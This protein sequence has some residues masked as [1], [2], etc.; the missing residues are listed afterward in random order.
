MHKDTI[1]FWTELLNHARLV[2]RR[3][4]VADVTEIEQWIDELEASVRAHI[5]DEL[6]AVRARIKEKRRVAVGPQPSRVRQDC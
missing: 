6:R 2:R 1:A 5:P 4:L 3:A